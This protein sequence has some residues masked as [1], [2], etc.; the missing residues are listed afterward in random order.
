MLQAGESQMVQTV[1]GPVR[2]YVSD[3][4]GLSVEVSAEWAVLVLSD[5]GGGGARAEFIANADT[6][7]WYA[8]D[9]AGRGS[10]E[11]GRVTGGD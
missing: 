1:F 2:V 9:A 5:C 4:A 3:D 11:G 8:D 7:T 10:R 6:A